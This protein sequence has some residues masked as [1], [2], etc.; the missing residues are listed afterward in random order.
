MF[1][2]I[3]S[4]LAKE[5]LNEGS[6]VSSHSELP[7][8]SI[9]NSIWSIWTPEMLASCFHGK[10][11][12]LFDRSNGG[13]H[14][15]DFGHLLGFDFVVFN[16]KTSKSSVKPFFL[17]ATDSQP[18]F[19]PLGSEHLEWRNPSRHRSI[20]VTGFLL[21][22]FQWSFSWCKFAWITGTVAL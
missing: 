18:L 2:A 5:S 19:L 3:S 7:A 14:I 6:T 17:R 13:M 16:L 10:A 15:I 4:H 22:S 12:N 9:Y 11:S 1:L 20:W 21:V 8:M